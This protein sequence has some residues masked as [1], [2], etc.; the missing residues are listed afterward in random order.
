MT[1][2]FEGGLQWASRSLAC[3]RCFVLQTFFPPVIDIT[4]FSESVDF[5]FRNEVIAHEFAA[6][7]DRTT[8]ADSR[9]C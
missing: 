3:C 6:L 9:C 4:C 5:E 7:N 8:D 1:D 2:R